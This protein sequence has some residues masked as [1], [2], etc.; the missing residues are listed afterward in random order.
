MLSGAAI[1]HSNNTI[2]CFCLSSLFKEAE[3]NACY[4]ILSNMHEDVM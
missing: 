4:F 3:A 2:N 1:Y